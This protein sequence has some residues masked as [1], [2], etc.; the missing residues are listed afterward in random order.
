VIEPTSPNSFPDGLE[1]PPALAD[2]VRAQ[3]ASEGIVVELSAHARADHSRDWWPRLM[4]GVAAGRIDN[5]PSAVVK[6]TSTHDV[7]VTLRIASEHRI[8]VTPQGG[9]S[10]VVGGATPERG[11]I[12]LDVTGL[13]RL[14]E[15]DEVS[16]TARVEAGI[17][18]PDLDAALVPHGFTVGHL[19][20][21]FNLATVG[22]W[23]A[24]RGAGQYSN[25]YGTIEDLVRGMTV[26][27]ASG[28]VLHLGGHGPRQAVGPDLLQ[29]FIGSEGTLGVIT[30][31]TLVL[32]RRASYE[33]RR[34]YSFATFREGLDA[35]RRILQ[36]GAR[37]AVLRLYDEVESR[38]H[39]DLDECALVVLDEGD[40]A[41]VEATITVV[42]E[43][44]THAKVRDGALVARWLERRN[45]VSAL[46]PLWER[47]LV[48][49]T[50][51]VAG[52]WSILDSLYERV[53]LTLRS[54]E[55]ILVVS[56]HQSHAYLDGACL[57]FT[58]AAQPQD[59][60]GFY[61]LAWDV[62]MAEVISAGGAV[63]H[64]HGVGR[65]R[66]RFVARALGDTFSILEGIKTQL[67]PQGIMNPGV[68]GLGA[69][70][71]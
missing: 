48:V 33:G 60:E 30:E 2:E 16:G 57:Y 12:A 37:P 54:L 17:F 38:R 61:R 53:T 69:P 40:P 64:H 10:S 34:A 43:E 45:D 22:G 49:D 31:A 56:V 20:Q 9:R 8:A 6:A 66:A 26:V 70:P 1:A 11:A 28:D 65:N 59:P 32:R 71:W 63:S 4:P 25:R 19:P 3:L 15:V 14:V 51:E 35:C 58:F 42:E 18:G 13:N 47:G 62:A 68:L 44:C 67:D 23:I 24:S 46:A 7:A 21:S 41:L 36:R 52:P 50:I 39:F 55:G 5:W 29:L 27:L